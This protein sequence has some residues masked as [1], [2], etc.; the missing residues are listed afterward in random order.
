MT[1]PLA[2]APRPSAAPDLRRHL[3]RMVVGVVVLDVAIALLKDRLGVETW[4]SQRRILFTAAWMLATLAVVLPTL[5]GIRRARV[6]ARRAR[7]TGR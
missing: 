5:A 6:R 2:S 1:G 7:A 4:P 3:L